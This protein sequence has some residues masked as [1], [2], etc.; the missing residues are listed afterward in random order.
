MDAKKKAD[1]AAAKAVAD[2]KIAADAAAVSAQAVGPTGTGLRYFARTKSSQSRAS[3]PR[4]SREYLQHANTG[5]QMTRPKQVRFLGRGV[6]NFDRQPITDED[7]GRFK[8]PGHPTLFVC[9]NNLNREKL[10]VRYSTSKLYKIS[11]TSI[12][13]VTK[14]VITELLFQNK[15]NSP[16]YDML[17]NNEK[18]K[19]ERL[20]QLMGTSSK[21]PGYNGPDSLRESYKQFEILRGEVANGNNAPQI[22]RQLRVIIG[23]LVASKRLTRSDANNIILQYC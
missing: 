22:K 17:D 19:V 7:E 16:L 18:Q 14:M 13:E 2:A 20:I 6:T 5:M 8:I 23:E 1:D 11:P 3:Q 15:F 4:A 21:L 12:S 10:A 9:L